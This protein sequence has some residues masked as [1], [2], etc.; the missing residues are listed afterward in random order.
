MVGYD[1]I[2]ILYTYDVGFEC[3]EI[4]QQRAVTTRAKQYVPLFVTKG[5]VVQVN[6]DRV[7]G[8]AL[9]RK[10]DLISDSGALIT[11]PGR[12]DVR[13]YSLHMRRRHGQ[14]HTG[15]LMA[16]LDIGCSFDQM[17]FEGSATVVSIAVELQEC[18]GQIGVI[19]SLDVK[20]YPKSSGY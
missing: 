8:G 20:R 5:I 4:G 18:L 10:C 19:E 12:L 17:L 9:D 14:M 1:V 16:V 3:L 7:R 15:S 11:T 2:Y 6:G 13:L